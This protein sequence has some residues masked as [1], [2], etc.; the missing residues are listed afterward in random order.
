MAL[1]FAIRSG[2]SRRN[3]MAAAIAA[4]V[5]FGV[6]AG[7]L[8]TGQKLLTI[9][10]YLRSGGVVFIDSGAFTAFR[11]GV[12]VDFNMVLNTYEMIA[13]MS[14]DGDASPTGLYVVSPDAVGD[15]VETLRLI[16]LYKE[17]LLALIGSGCNLIVP[18]QRGAIEAA[19]MLERV[20]SIL[21][22]DRFVAG[23]PSNEEAMSVKECATLEH[24]SFHIL[25]RVQM[26]DE[27][28]A[29]I[30][31]LRNLHPQAEITA[32]AN[33]MRSRIDRICQ[34]T[35]IVR[36]EVYLSGGHKPH[37]P[38]SRTIALTKLLGT[39]RHW[40]TMPGRAG[41]AR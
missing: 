27:Q 9:P 7:E 6:V 3:D 30:E 4:R 39:D 19:Q 31:A 20:K 12:P 32:D 5:P 38:S 36:T 2:M 24:H 37:Q 25:G 18:I 23:I 35:D 13:E 10:K 40:G 8:V 33:W 34:H 15:Q 41:A 1:K 29:R 14:Q 22:T 26:N 11:T 16:A 17:R 28:V 21:Q